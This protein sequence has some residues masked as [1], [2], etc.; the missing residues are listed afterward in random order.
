MLQ[1]AWNLTINMTLSEKMNKQQQKKKKE[2]HKTLN[3]WSEVEKLQQAGAWCVC[4]G[5]QRA[6]CS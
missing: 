2:T 3:I 4:G 5:M 1:K 6:L